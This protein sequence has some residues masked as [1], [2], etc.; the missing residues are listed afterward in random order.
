MSISKQHF[1][2]CTYDLYV[3]NDTERELVEQATQEAPL[4][5][6]QGT[7][8]MLPAF[9]AQLEGKN[10]GDTF[11]FVLSAEDAYGERREDYI[12]DLDRNLFVNEEGQFDDERVKEGEMVP[13]LDSEGNQLNG[14]VLSITDTTV[15][16]DFNHPL[17][18]EQL[19]FIGV[20]LEEREATEEDA[21][22]M[23]ALLQGQH[24][25]CGDGDCGGGCCSSC[26]CH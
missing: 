15:R 18:G 20:V 2:T 10:V 14:M 7:D 5:Y 16:V 9:E 12:L 25:G 3:G 26:G 11:D 23:E 21:Q 22:F 24:Q 17:A 4:K 6:I 19:H 8:T 13:M 1:V